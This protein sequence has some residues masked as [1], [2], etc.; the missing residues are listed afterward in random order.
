MPRALRRAATNAG[1]ARHVEPVRPH[2]GPDEPAFRSSRSAGRASVAR[3][4]REV[5]RKRRVDPQQ[6]A[7]DLHQI[8]EVLDAL[9]VHLELGQ[10]QRQHRPA[11]DRRLEERAGAPDRRPRWL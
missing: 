5:L 1:V 10:Q 2:E 4:C 8:A 11:D 9:L 6:P 3:Q 7:F